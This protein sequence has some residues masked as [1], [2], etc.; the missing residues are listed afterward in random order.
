M[1]K[2]SRVTAL[3]VTAAAL[4]PIASLAPGSPEHPAAVTAS[5][6]KSAARSKPEANDYHRISETHRRRTDVPNMRERMV[7][8]DI[9]IHGGNVS[10][11]NRVLALLT[12][13]ARATSSTMPS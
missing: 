1:S 9:A 8:V 2:L 10:D 7:G 12:G 13:R 11:R 5:P 3:T 4:L 6:T